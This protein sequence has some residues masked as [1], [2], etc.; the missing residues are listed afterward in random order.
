M[1]LGDIRLWAAAGRTWKLKVKIHSL[2]LKL[3]QLEDETDF[4]WLASLGLA[5]D[6]N[7]ETEFS[8]WDLEPVTDIFWEYGP[9]DFGLAWVFETWNLWFWHYLWLGLYNVGLSCDLNHIIGN[10]LVTLTYDLE[11]V[12]V[13]DPLNLDSLTLDLLQGWDL[14]PWDLKSM[15]LALMVTWISWFGT[16][17]CFGVWLENFSWLQLMCWDSL[18]IWTVWFRVC[19]WLV[20]WLEN[21]LWLGS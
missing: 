12:C 2:R 5:F 18:A 1:T 7:P 10:T 6:L 14:G 16:S 21:S 3:H 15:I 4:T 19:L 9:L 8:T 13:S 11:L 17:F 20:I